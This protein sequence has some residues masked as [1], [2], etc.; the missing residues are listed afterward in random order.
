M[1][2]LI[3]ICAFAVL[4]CTSLHA[5][6]TESNYDLQQSTMRIDQNVN[7][8]FQQRYSHNYVNS[9]V[10]LTKLRD[11]LAQAWQ[12]LGL[13]AQAA[14]AVANAYKPNLARGIHHDS[15]S[16]K[17][18]QEI[19]TMLQSALTKGDYMMANQTLIDY[20]QNQVRIGTHRS[21][22]SRH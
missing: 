21:P 18:S 12:G 15:L 22:G 19:A 3:L 7:S 14:Q 5:Q 4:A 10:D 20:E 8:D 16:G 17:S 11:N 2:K 9:L 13:S 1:M 6:N